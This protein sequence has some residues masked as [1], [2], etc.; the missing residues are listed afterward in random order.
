MKKL[1]VS[2]TAASL[3]VVSAFAKDV[4]SEAMENLLDKKE[5]QGQPFYADSA[6]RSEAI[7]KSLK[8]KNIES[9]IHEKGYRNSPLTKRQQQ[10]NRKKSKI[11]A[12]VEHI[13]AFMENSMHGTRRARGTAPR[14]NSTFAAQPSLV[15]MGLSPD[16]LMRSRM[17]EMR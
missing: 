5:D 10:R 14:R 1:L 4:D 11:R 12:R 7:E 15:T 13:F 17:S 3:V 9:Q 2:V 6:Y 16:A 8:K